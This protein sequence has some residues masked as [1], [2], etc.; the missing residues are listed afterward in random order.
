MVPSFL[1]NDAT[2]ELRE[3]ELASEVRALPKFLV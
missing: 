3:A 1:H 2:P